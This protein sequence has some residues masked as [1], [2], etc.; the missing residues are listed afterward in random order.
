M[1]FLWFTSWIQFNPCKNPTSRDI[2]PPLIL[3]WLHRN[4]IRF[5]FQAF[6]FKKSYQLIHC[7]V[8][9]LNPPYYRIVLTIDYRKYLITLRN[10]A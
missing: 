1:Q 4:R 7:P 5:Q 10:L 6:E 2:A 3:L 9:Y 8:Q